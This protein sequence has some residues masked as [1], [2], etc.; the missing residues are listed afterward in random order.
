MVSEK[1]CITTRTKQERSEPFLERE[2]F[3]SFVLGG[4]PAA[5]QKHPQ[6]MAGLFQLRRS[7]LRM[8]IF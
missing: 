1:F 2:G 5:Q 3:G 7:A 8:L 6:R 4:V